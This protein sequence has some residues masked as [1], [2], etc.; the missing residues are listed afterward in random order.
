MIASLFF[1]IFLWTGIC[2]CQTNGAVFRYQ[3]KFTYGLSQGSSSEVSGGNGIVLVVPVVYQDPKVLVEFVRPL[4][5]MVRFG[6]DSRLNAIGINTDIKTGQKLQQIIRKLDQKSA[7]VQLEIRILEVSSEW[8]QSHPN[9]S[10]MMMQKT[11][12]SDASLASILS[13]LS[14]SGQSRIL[15][16]PTI[17]TLDGV[18]GSIN[19]GDSI[20]YL[21]PIR[22]E[23][24]IAYDVKTLSVGI[25][26]DVCPRVVSTNC[27]QVDVASS[28]SSVKTWRTLENG[29]YPILTSR[30]NESKVYLNPQ[31]SLVMG[32]LL[33]EQERQSSAGIP[34]LKDLPIVGD[35]FRSS[36]KEKITTDIVFVI[37]P[38][39][40]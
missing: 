9:I 5:P 32:G 27:I 18:K 6:V 12:V 11:L 31:E 23:N 16:K 21:V 26:C 30:K 22:H 7:L 37:T 14:S 39:I 10:T 40:L 3:N 8:L 33:D 17:V 20:P 19:V 28:I 24:Y 29:N 34:V 13:E 38:R 4:F 36:K 15:A 2:F 35:F 1:L 25:Q